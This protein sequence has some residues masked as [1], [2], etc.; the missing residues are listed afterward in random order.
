VATVL[1]VVITAV[2][3]IVAFWPHP[4]DAPVEQR[5]AA[6]VVLERR[7]PPTP[8]PT[9]KPTPTPTPPPTPTP[10]PTVHAT[11][12][13]VTERAAPRAHATPGGTGIARPHVP[14]PV[15]PH[16]AVANAPGN[17]AGSG[18]GTANGSDAGAGNG[19]GGTGAGTIDANAPCGY[20]EFLPS[21]APR[22]DGT[23][24]YETIRATVHYP[25]GR[26]ESD[27]FPYP[28]VYADY[29]NTDPWSPIN[30]RKND[31]VVFAQ[32]PPPGTD[33]HRYNELIR[34]ILDHTTPSGHTVLQPCPR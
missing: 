24:S 3:A 4:Y 25:D 17:G 12:A 7:A 10:V 21:E 20:V 15:H 11:P 34:Y 23:T 8:R 14:H 16:I 28:W 9:P 33:I 32:L 19:T 6:N 29:M 1:G 26:T 30:V 18:S 2:E 13:I 31:L 22:I 27:D 5:V